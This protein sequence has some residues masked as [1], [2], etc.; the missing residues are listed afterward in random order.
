MDQTA[1][2]AIFVFVTFAVS[3]AGAF[4]PHLVKMND[5]QTH[6][7][8]AFSAG[9]FVGVLFLMFLPH[10]I[11]ESQESGFGIREIMYAVMGGF[12]AV[13]LLDLIVKHFITSDCGCDECMDH[14]SHDVTSMSAFIGLAIHS[15]F[16]GLALAS[17]FIIGGGAGI[18]VLI[19]LCIHKLVVV[20]S[21]SST[22]LL[23]TKKKSAMK[24]LFAFCLI[25]PAAA[26]VSYLFLGGM[27]LEWTGLALAVSAGIF[28][29]VTMCNMIPEAF[30]RK[31]RK[32]SSFAMV[33]AGVAVAIAV[34]MITAYLAH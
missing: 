12:L 2:F 4:L 33:L 13:L 14:H 23:S 8:I 28:M 25:S 16:D 26:V 15:C 18:T 17:S 1:M 34:V 10:A 19:A 9:I 5:R 29:F 27:S 11:G 31:E 6:L 22:F 32:F 3:L 21:L 24:Y 7:M 30:H 20:F